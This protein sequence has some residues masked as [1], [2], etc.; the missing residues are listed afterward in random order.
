MRAIGRVM[1]IGLMLGLPARGETPAPTP[2]SADLPT[3]RHEFALGAGL[4]SNDAYLLFSWTSPSRVGAYLRMFPTL[5]NTDDYSA[6]SI[7]IDESAGEIGVAVRVR[8]WV[9]VGAG[10]G[11]YERTDT[12]YGN[13]DPLF[14]VPEWLGEVTEEDEGLGAIGIF[15]LPSRSPN[16]AFSVSV[17][18]SPA[19]SGASLGATFGK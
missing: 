2:P 3:R 15:T 16:V 10:Y 18:M 9:T 1:M 17:S 6:N 5:E 8:R 14:G 7:F 4:S 19:G 13:P 12:T 11:V